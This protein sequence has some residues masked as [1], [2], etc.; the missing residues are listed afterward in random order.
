MMHDIRSLEFG[1]GNWSMTRDDS[2]TT[3]KEKLER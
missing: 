1:F 3:A 2:V